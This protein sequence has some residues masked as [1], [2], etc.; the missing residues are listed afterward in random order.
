MSNYLQDIKEAITITGKM[1]DRVRKIETA[2]EI[3]GNREPSTA[4][5]Q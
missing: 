4:T 5:I 3:C 1:S 2:I